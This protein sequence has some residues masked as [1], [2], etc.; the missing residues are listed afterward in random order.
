MKFVSEFGHLAAFSHASG[1]NLSDVE[2][3]GRVGE[4]YGS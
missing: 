3:E 4:I 2:N 1:S